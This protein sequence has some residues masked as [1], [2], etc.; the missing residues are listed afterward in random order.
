MK[1]RKDP[2]QKQSAKMNVDTFQR[3]FDSIMNGIMITDP[4]G[5]VTYM[6]KPYGRFLGL[7]SQEQIGRHCT[8]VVEN[9]RMHIVGK[10]GRAEINHLQE[11]R[12]ENI[13]VQ[14]IPIK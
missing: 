4:G 9:S 8:E 5:Y 14:R 11:I 3:I 10:T 12:G 13:V 2:G 7:S 6:N 1:K